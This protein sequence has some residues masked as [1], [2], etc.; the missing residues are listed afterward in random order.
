M[1]DDLL[2]LFDRDRKQQ[3]AGQKRGGI[4]GMLDRLRDDDDDRRTYNEPQ[5]R[6]YHDD[7]DDDD[8]YEDSR[9]NRKRERDGFDFFDD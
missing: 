7:D 5:R 2:D 9:R 8:R 3:P 4:R 6:R 1:L